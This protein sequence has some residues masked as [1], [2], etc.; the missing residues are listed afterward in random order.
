MMPNYIQKSPEMDRVADAFS[1]YIHRHPNL[2]LVWSEKIGYVLMTINSDKQRG[3]DY[4]SFRTAHDL[5][6]RLFS[7]VVTDVVLECED[8]DDVSNLGDEGREEVTRRSP[9]VADAFDGR[10]DILVLVLGYCR[11]IHAVGELPNHDTDLAEFL[12]NELRVRLR[13]VPY[14]MHGVVGEFR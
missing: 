1:G 13:Q 6:F 10:N 3:E 5:A 4:Y 2:D 12:L 9:A 7:E 11:G 8:C 14:R